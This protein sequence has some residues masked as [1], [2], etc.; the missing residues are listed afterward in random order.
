MDSL[1]KS[2][3][4]VFRKLPPLPANIV[5]VLVGITPWIALIFGILGVLG[6][7][8]GLGILTVFAPLAVVS[9]DRGFGLGYI[10]TIGLGLSSLLMLAAFPGVK[11]RKA[12]GWQLLFWSEVVNVVA[13][14][15]GLSVGSI[16]GA[17]I[18]FY[19]LFQIKPRYK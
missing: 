12:S 9:G 13:S 19:L 8:A 18:A 16:I 1:V 10:S 5:D 4:D 6:A 11:A 15:V 7:L 2:L 3:E 17:I 14:L